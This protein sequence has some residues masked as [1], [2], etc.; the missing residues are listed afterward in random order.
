VPLAANSETVLVVEDDEDV[1]NYTVSS[2]RELGYVVFEAID[3]TSALEIVN[4]EP[5]IHLL[6]TD[7]GLPGA[8]DGRGL[9]E[10]V[11]SI[12]P[13][14][15]ILMTTA[16]AGSVL[17][18]EGRLAPGVELLSKPFTFAALA[19]RIRELMDRREPGREGDRILVVDDEILIRM[20]V[21]DTLARGGLEVEEAG[22]FHEAVAKIRS[23]GDKLAAAIIDL[24]LPDGSGDGL[25]A[26]IRG[27]WPTLPI[28]LATGYAS[29]DIRKRFAQDAL[30]Q[31]VAKPFDPE[32]L[33]GVLR[34]FGV[35]PRGASS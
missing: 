30:L 27:L 24:G 19:S 21:V 6:F 3:G 1:R 22:S 25:V 14:L 17:I 9:A 12:R 2:L 16:Y 33:L 5:S 8:F 13:S 4:R 28:I 15:K 32:A 18:H 26:D 34:R 23:V 10:R 7:L 20:L 35:E 31:I 11:R 29:E